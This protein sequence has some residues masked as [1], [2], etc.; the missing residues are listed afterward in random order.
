MGTLLVMEGLDGC[1]KQTQT[2]R[3][4][5]TFRNAAVPHRRVSFP[6]YSQH[7]SALVKMYLQ[8][9]FGPSPR[10]VNP[11]AASS[12]YA[13]DRFASYQKFWKHDYESGKVILADRYTTSNLVYQLPKV[14]RDD[15]DAFTEWLLDFEYHRFELPI[16]DLTLFLDMSPAASESLLEKRYHGDEQKKDIHEKSIAFQQE[17]RQ[18]ALYAAGKLKWKVVSCDAGGKLRTPKEIHADILQIV[19]EQALL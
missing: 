1:G 13:V 16:P 11:Y 15:W 8:G 9:E 5:T 19:Q 14:P 6:D 17:C 12:F 18:A 7:S 3:L 2:A 10:D 4:C